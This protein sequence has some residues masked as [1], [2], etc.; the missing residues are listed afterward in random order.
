MKNKIIEDVLSRITPEE[1]VKYEMK[2][3]NELI[4]ISNTTFKIILD[5]DWQKGNHIFSYDPY[6]KED[7]PINFYNKIKKFLGLKF[8]IKESRSRGVI[9]KIHTDGTIE[10][11]K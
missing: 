6:T 9:Y 10:Y 1:H 4:G 2:I 5:E 11:I 8:K 3:E 7:I